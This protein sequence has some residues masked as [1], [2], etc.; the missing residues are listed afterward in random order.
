MIRYN[1]KGTLDSGMTFRE[2]ESFVGN[3]LR[4][5][6]KPSS[7]CELNFLEPIQ[8]EG[9]QRKELATATQAAV[10]AAFEASA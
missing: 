7:N 2:D 3:I 1:Q 8:S 10:S 9:R 6:G 5:L 4:L